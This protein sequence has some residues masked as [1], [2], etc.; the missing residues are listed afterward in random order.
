MAR[1]T[2]TLDMPGADGPI[3][4]H[5]LR[6]REAVSEAFR[7]EV[8]FSAPG[9]A[10]DDA[11]GAVATLHVE[12]TEGNERYVSGV[13]QSLSVAA[14]NDSAAR[15]RAVLVPIQSLIAYRNGF[16]IFQDQDVTEIVATVFKDAGFPDKAFR[17]STSKSY[18]KRTYCVQYDETEW[19]FICRILEDEGIWFAFDQTASGHVMVFAD[20]STTAKALD[21]QELGFHF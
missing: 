2:A 3:L 17:W 10:P 8:D 6:G 14:N 19:A 20:D 5:A 16:R 9:M 12:D 7:Y 1:L 21:P 11:R 15:M 13:V 18:R 4:V